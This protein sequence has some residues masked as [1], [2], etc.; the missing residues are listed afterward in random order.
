MLFDK[1]FSIK[2]L[3]PRTFAS[4]RAMRV[5]DAIL[6]SGQIGPARTFIIE[7]KFLGAEKK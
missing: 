2:R 4:Q 7:P 3:T 5:K 1:M 6:K